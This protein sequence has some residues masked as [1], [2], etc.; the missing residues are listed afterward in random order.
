MACA[1]GWSRRSTGTCGACARFA[2]REWAPQR[3]VSR[4]R[5]PRSEEEGH[6]PLRNC[7]R[8]PAEGKAGRGPGNV[9]PALRDPAARSGRLLHLQDQRAAPQLPPAS[10]DA[11]APARAPREGSPRPQALPL[12]QAGHDADL[13]LQ[14][15]FA[16]SSWTRHRRG[17]RAHR[18]AG[19]VDRALPDRGGPDLPRVPRR[20]HGGPAAA[21]R[22]RTAGHFPDQW[23]HLHLR[24]ALGDAVPHRPRE[25]L[26]AAGA[27]PQ[28]AQRV[29]PS[30]PRCGPGRLRRQVHSLWRR[31]D[32]RRIVHP[33]QPPV[34][35]GSR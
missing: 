9:R 1:R 27:R 20:G 8:A 28:D 26:L 10:A 13:G 3:R 14:P 24:P 11:A 29:G 18:G 6:G 32:A 34:R 31:P 15:R 22:P 30:R 33:A 4:I 25:Q 19:F 16:G 21:C 35:R 5:P 7:R 23:L 12:H 17:V 2:L